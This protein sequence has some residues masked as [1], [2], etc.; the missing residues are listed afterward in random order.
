MA[1]IPEGK[2]ARVRF[3]IHDVFVRFRVAGTLEIWNRIDTGNRWDNSYKMDGF[4]LRRL[5]PDYQHNT[6]VL[7]IEFD[8]Y[9]DLNNP[10]QENKIPVLVDNRHIDNLIIRS[11][12]TFLE[13]INHLKSLVDL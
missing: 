9:P 4:G 11:D 3:Y 2:T 6:V 1:F 13:D 7:D 8:S 10:N 5:D 12:D